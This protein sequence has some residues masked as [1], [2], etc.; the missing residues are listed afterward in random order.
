MEMFNISL[1][2]GAVMLIAFIATKKTRLAVVVAIVTMA[3]LFAHSM[4]VKQADTD[5]VIKTASQGG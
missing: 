2:I 1:L 3:F 5:E 4:L